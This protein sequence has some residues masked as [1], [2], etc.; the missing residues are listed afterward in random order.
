MMHLSKRKRLFLFKPF[1]INDTETLIFG[2]ECSKLYD[3]K[4]KNVLRLKK[5]ESCKKNEF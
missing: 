4:Y 2:A 3:K 5:T 1:S